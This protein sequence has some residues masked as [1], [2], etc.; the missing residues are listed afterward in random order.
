MQALSM[1]IL[2]ENTSHTTLTSKVATIPE[3]KGSFQT[4][5]TFLGLAVSNS[6]CQTCGTCHF[7]LLQD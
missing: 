7:V 3:I 1:C 5:I 2:L 6:F 4:L